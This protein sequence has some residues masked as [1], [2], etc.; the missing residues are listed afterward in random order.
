[1]P[2]A[3]FSGRQKVAPVVRLGFADVSS[4]I[5]RLSGRQ[6][7][8]LVRPKK[9]SLHLQIIT[10]S[11]RTINTSTGESKHGKRNETR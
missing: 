1:M 2:S 8:A 4:P 11:R 6:N 7:I 9:T 5:A 10:P 3:R